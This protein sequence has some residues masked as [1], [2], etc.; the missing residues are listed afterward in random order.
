LIPIIVAQL[1]VMKQQMDAKDARIEAL[2]KA[3]AKLNGKK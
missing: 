3:L 2:E 1:Q